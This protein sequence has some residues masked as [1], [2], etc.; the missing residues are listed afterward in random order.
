MANLGHFLKEVKIEMAKVVWPTS[1]QLV[2]YTIIV[3]LMSVVLAAFLGAL[4]LGFQT[5]LNKFILK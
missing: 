1:R 5:L 2:V 4:D 3:I